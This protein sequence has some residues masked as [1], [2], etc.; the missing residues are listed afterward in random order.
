MIPFASQRGSGRDLATHLLN[1]ED[2]EY[3]EIDDLRG[4]VADDLHGAFAEWEAQAAAMTKCRNY[5]YS[6]SINPDHR[7][8][9]LPRDLY[10]DYVERV[11]E[12]LGLAGQPRAIVF[13]IKE[14][15]EHAHV[16]WSR[17]DLQEMKAIHMAFDHDA[18]MGVTRRF[19]RDH[20]IELAPGYH[21][22][23]ERK[24]QTHRQLS[25]YEK[26]QI[27]ESGISREERIATV[28]ELWHR[29]DTAQS[30]LASLE[31]HGYLLAQGKRP[32]VLVDI[33]GHTNA[34]PK[35]ID[36]KAAT[37]KAIRTFLGEA[38]KAE[39]LPT[40]DEAKALAARHRAALK[41][42]RQAEDRA[43]R[44]DALKARQ[45]LR[46]SKLEKEAERLK[47]RQDDEKARAAAARDAETRDHQDRYAA[48]I[49]LIREQRAAARPTGLPG[50]LARVT[51]VAFLRDKLHAHQ[52]AR[53]AAA[54]LEEQRVIAARH[55]AAHRALEHGQRLQALDMERKRQALKETENRERRSLEKS[56]LQEARTRQRAGQRHMPRLGLELSPPGR[57][58]APAKAMHRHTNPLA[59]EL[60]MAKRRP[61][62]EK[63]KAPGKLQADFERAAR[64][65]RT[66]VK[67]R[68]GDGGRGSKAPKRAR[69]GDR[70][71]SRR[72]FTRRARD[73]GKGRE[74]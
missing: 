56:F 21:R 61:A 24:R 34:L 67:M 5:L 19:A 43:D 9:P 59:R 3:L 65:E 39:N 13:H 46:R 30:F 74:R 44:L 38:G 45:E 37:T 41:E 54:H 12:A 20:G 73:D 6:L 17:I 2:N 26:A 57:R 29:R 69:Q 55:E 60:A 8:G 62:P 70:D 15:R 27:E 42:H 64:G 63:P 50:F 72:V 40:V 4:S 22:L 48:R 47:A 25:L 1:A 71:G 68:E 31:H 51:G 35:L 18:L 36:D 11:E 52:D 32:F 16:V 7:Q 66:E 58:A 33:Y 49:A 10:A 28:T 53:R 23:E 14:G